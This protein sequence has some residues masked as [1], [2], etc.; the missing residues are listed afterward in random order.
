MKINQSSSTCIGSKRISGDAAVRINYILNEKQILKLYNL[1]PLLSH[2]DTN[3]Q[4][5]L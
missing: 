2:F 4:L 5:T 3:P 1:H